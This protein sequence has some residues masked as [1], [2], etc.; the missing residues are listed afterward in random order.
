[1]SNFTI[2]LKALIV[3][4]GAFLS[5]KLGILYPILALL[6]AAMILDYITGILAGA[7]KKEIS[8]K[9]GMWGI[10]KKLCYG[11]AVAVAMIVDWTVLNVAGEIGINIDK[12]VFFSLLITIWLIFNELTSILENLVKLDVEL[13]SFLAKIVSKMKV[14][15]NEAGN[16]ITD[17]IK[18]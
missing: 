17:N 2:E 11:I 5:A 6:L 9:K 10:I 1:M 12:T 8:S 3:G 15:A 16:K 14:T 7:Y 13:P 4:V 18:E